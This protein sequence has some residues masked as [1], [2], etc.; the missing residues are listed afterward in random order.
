MLRP[1]HSEVHLQFIVQPVTLAA[2]HGSARHG[3]AY[4]QSIMVVPITG[5]LFHFQR[6]TMAKKQRYG[7]LSPR[8]VRLIKDYLHKVYNS[9][10]LRGCVANDRV[11]TVKW[12]ECSKLKLMTR[13][14]G[15]RRERHGLFRCGAFPSGP[16][17]PPIDPIFGSGVISP[18]RIPGGVTSSRLVGSDFFQGPILIA[19]QCGPFAT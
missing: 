9:P 1:P 7:G 10:D 2:Q 6:N 5:R 4:H 12:V 15:Q 3:R 19:W 8:Y 14:D 11:R 18:A 17:S 16:Y 13:I